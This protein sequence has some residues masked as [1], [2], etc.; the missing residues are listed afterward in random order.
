LGSFIEPKGRFRW[1]API[2]QGLVFGCGVLLGM[3]N[4]AVVGEGSHFDGRSV[5]LSIA[6]AFYGPLASATA[7]IMAV[8]L[9]LWQGGADALTGC[10]V[11]AASA[12]IGSL[13]YFRRADRGTPFS[14]R[15]LLGLGLSTH[16]AMLALMLTLP[17][18][19][20]MPTLAAVALPVITLYPLAGL[21]LGLLIN[22]TLLQRRETLEL[23]RSVSQLRSLSDNI[24][25]GMIYQVIIHADGRREFTY[26]SDSVRQLYG[27][28]PE[29]I[30]ANPIRIYSR[31]HPE[32][33][34]AL[35]EAEEA[36]MKAMSQFR[37]ECRI[38]NPSGSLRWSALVSKP[39]PGSHGSV[40]WDGIELDIS[41]IKE[42][43]ARLQDAL[44]EKE[45]LIRELYHRTKNTLQVIRSLLLLQAGERLDDPGVQAVAAALDKRILAI[46]LVHQLLYESRDLHQLSAREYLTAL[47]RLVAGGREQDTAPVYLDINVADTPLSIDIAIPLGI[48]INE[49]LANSLVH[50]TSNTA[51]LTIAIQLSP[52][53]DGK[54]LRLVYHDDGPGLPA[55]Y[56]HV[57]ASSLGMLMI[58]EIATQQLRGRL[59]IAGP[60][61]FLY[62]L[63]FDPLQESPP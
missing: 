42:T 49:L 54:S 24:S 25:G 1:V 29:E 46:A 4:P 16:A 8:A 30:R 58:H 20:A 44:E 51:G 62:Q 61:G 43:E 38:I 33:R 53:Q 32:D 13:F 27:A 5:L 57:H 6:G 35:G 7:G 48:I 55:G 15:R 19:R 39:S 3:L 9:R 59:D 40:V 60:P 12:L 17:D 21:I 37:H 2:I 45:T 11:I 63:E 23:A 28:T 14:W 22:R 47:A 31:V 41:G 18:G 26:V 52:C 34:Q 10:L 50:A 56:D 36:A